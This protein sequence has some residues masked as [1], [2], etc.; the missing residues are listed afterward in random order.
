MR[1]DCFAACLLAVTACGTTALPPRSE[2][3]AHVP[4]R[5]AL[6]SVDPRTTVDVLGVSLAVH[7]SDP[8]GTKPAIV[9]LHAIGHGGRDYAAFAATFEADYRII[10]VDWPG[11][12]ASSVDREPASA[13]RYGE[14]FAA[15]VG[16]LELETF[17]IV[18]NSIGGAVAISY[19]AKHPEWVAGL[20][21]ANPA[22]LDP[23]GFF[24]SLYIKHLERKF[25]AGVAGQPRFQ[26][27]FDDYYDDILRTP[28][29]Q[30][31]RR[32]IVDAG[33]EMAPV[34][35]QAWRSFRSPQADLR[36]L[37]PKVSMPVLFAWARKDRRVRWSRN[38]AAVRTFPNAKVVHFDV[39]HSPFL[40]VP[41][42]FNAA[43]AEFLS[44]LENGESGQW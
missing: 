17:V 32:K 18:G 31:H 20:I 33:Y 25:R 6:A 13:A 15:L 19:A 4:R 3:D 2:L 36:R 23:G 16:Q 39:G 35:E 44:S 43:A 40:E 24:S 1:T 28:V 29:A 22:G 42:A 14:L 11:H 8:T 37:I 7:D 9:C 5:H 10:T 30:E 12:G 27:W 21:L 38:E 34:L 26:T 41:E